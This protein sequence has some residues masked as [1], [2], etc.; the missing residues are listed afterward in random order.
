MLRATKILPY[1]VLLYSL[2]ALRNVEEDSTCCSF[3]S[4]LIAPL[5]HR[6]VL[7]A[8]SH[9]DVPRAWLR[10]L[11][12][13]RF[14][15]RECQGPRPNHPE[16][17]PLLLSF[18]CVSPSRCQL[19]FSPTYFC[20][21]CSRCSWG[22][23]ATSLHS[24]IHRRRRHSSLARLRSHDVNHMLMRSRSLRGAVRRLQD[25]WPRSAI[26]TVSMKR[27]VLRP[28]DLSMKAPSWIRRFLLKIGWMAC[29]FRLSGMAESHDQNSASTPR[30]SS[31]HQQC[32]LCV[33]ASPIGVSTQYSH[34]WST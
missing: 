4:H 13:F 8:F 28:I 18:S 12:L 33:L 9:S 19:L 21:D 25:C 15:H 23:S 1:V 22:S 34:A 32:P 24:V 5:S 2:E 14:R 30:Y 11:L 17:N 20:L 31:H 3:A 26:P 7:C 10:G 29:A 6:G 16:R 27:A